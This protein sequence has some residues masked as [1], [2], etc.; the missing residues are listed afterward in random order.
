MGTRIWRT[1]CYTGLVC[2]LTIMPVASQRVHKD[3]GTIGKYEDWLEHFNI[4]EEFLEKELY[5]VICTHSFPYDGEIGCMISAGREKAQSWPL[6]IARYRVDAVLQRLQPQSA[7][8]QNISDMFPR[9]H[10]TWVY[11]RFL[12]Q[13]GLEGERQR[14]LS[15]SA[16][17]LMFFLSREEEAPCECVCARR[18][19]LN[20]C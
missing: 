20:R 9:R 11:V 2:F 19:P 1:L 14:R 15:R 7:H 5:E 17:L 13:L 3:V 8:K 18:N 16:F 10:I 12:E 4:L 6:R